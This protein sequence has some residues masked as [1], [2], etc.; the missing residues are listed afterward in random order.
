MNSV[1]GI[2][3]IDGV[4]FYSRI[5]YIQMPNSDWMAAIFRDPDGPWHMGSRHRIYRD[6][7]YFHSKDT[8]RFVGSHAKDGSAESLALLRRVTESF[9]E[10]TCEAANGVLTTLVLDTADPKV[11]AEALMKQPWAHTKVVLAAEGGQA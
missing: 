4:R 3:D 9:A 6:N 10:L 2:F 11:I 5:Y 8:K 1:E 7:R